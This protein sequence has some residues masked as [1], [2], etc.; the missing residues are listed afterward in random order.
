M[1][2]QHY[3]VGGQKG[4][5]GENLKALLHG[6]HEFPVCCWRRHW[7]L[8]KIVCVID[9]SEYF[10]CHYSPTNQTF[11]FYVF[12]SLSELMCLKSLPAAHATWMSKRMSVFRHSKCLPTNHFYSW[13]AYFME[14]QM[15]FYFVIWFPAEQKQ[16]TLVGWSTS[17]LFRWVLG[18]FQLVKL[19][20][21]AKTSLA[22][23]A[24]QVD[25]I[26]DRFTPRTITV[27]ITINLKV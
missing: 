20:K 19:A 1:V 22:S 17:G 9:Q 15:A 4:S 11:S 12:L 26:K 13:L 14:K 16:P 8:A 3:H 5:E 23:L 18:T 2:P 25:Q 10:M 6:N 21:P 27:M 7:K 24:D